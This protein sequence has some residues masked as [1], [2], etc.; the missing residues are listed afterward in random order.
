MVRFGRNEVALVEDWRLEGLSRR[1]VLGGLG[2]GA[3]FFF[4]G[5]A[6]DAVADGG[7]VSVEPLGDDV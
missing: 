3:G 4:L 5:P 6:V 1:V 2:A 7:S